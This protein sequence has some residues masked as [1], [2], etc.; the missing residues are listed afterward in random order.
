MKLEEMVFKVSSLS[1]K[2]SLDPHRIY[3]LVDFQD[4]KRMYRKGEDNLDLSFKVIERYVRMKEDL[5]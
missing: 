1:R 3:E 5:K 2:Y 4:A